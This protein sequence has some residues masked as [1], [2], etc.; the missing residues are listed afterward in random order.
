M[1]NETAN[2]EVSIFQVTR[3]GAVAMSTYATDV[4]DLTVREIRLLQK[5]LLQQVGRWEHVVAQKLKDD[6]NR[7]VFN[8][9]AHEFRVEHLVR[10]PDDSEP[11]DQF[12]VAV[13][14]GFIGLVEGC[15]FGSDGV[16]PM[17]RNFDLTEL[18]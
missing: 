3:G 10:D 2:T 14:V 1:P 16:E 6:P 13:V 4:S 9:P 18:D 5:Y 8:V 11:E 7:M 12:D 15:I 17:G